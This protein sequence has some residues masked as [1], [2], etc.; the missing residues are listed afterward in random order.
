M[1][2]RMRVT[3]GLA[4]AELAIARLATMLEKRMVIETWSID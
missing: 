4:P 2:A 3:Y 1:V